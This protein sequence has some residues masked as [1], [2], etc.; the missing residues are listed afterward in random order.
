MTAMRQRQRRRIRSQ[1]R[2]IKY[3][4]E[5]NVLP[6]ISLGDWGMGQEICRRDKGPISVVMSDNS[7]LVKRAAGCWSF[8]EAR[9]GSKQTY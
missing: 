3:K 9:C 2:R 4:D 6:I 7:L 5:C 1:R 8:D